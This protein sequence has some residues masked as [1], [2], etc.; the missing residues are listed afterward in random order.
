MIPSPSFTSSGGRIPLA[1]AT[2]TN[3]FLP[4]DRSSRTSLDSNSNSFH[5]TQ[6]PRQRE[7]QFHSLMAYLP[8]SKL[9]K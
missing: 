7:M 5:Y 1:N 2:L 8:M 6:S 3:P 4:V 9:V